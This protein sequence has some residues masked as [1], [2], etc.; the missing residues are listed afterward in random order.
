M[1]DIVNSA[2]CPPS[3]MSTLP[4]PKFSMLPLFTYIST[5]II[6]FVDLV[7]HL[8]FCYYLAGYVKSHT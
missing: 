8:A 1:F 3:T 5:Y 7:L 4:S 6:S 2:S